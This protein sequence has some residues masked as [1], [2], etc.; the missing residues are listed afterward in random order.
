MSEGNGN[1][2]LLMHGRLHRHGKFL[3]QVEYVLFFLEHAAEILHQP[4]RSDLLPRHAGQCDHAHHGHRQREAPG[5]RLHAA[6]AL[7]RLL[8]SAPRK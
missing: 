4:D 5:V 2:R 6:R 8:M 7:T 3:I 1:D